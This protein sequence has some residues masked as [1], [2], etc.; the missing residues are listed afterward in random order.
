M[1]TRN[2]E[3]LT[4]AAAHAIPG[5]YDICAEEITRLMAKALQGGANGAFDAIT[6]AF[7]YGFICGNRATRRGK[8]K[9]M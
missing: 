1:A 3:A 8:A 2:M 5:D 9:A 6:T 4:E 7:V